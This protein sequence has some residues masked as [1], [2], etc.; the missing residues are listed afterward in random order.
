MYELSISHSHSQT[1]RQHYGMMRRTRILEI[2]EDKYKTKVNVV[3]ITI[4]MISTGLASLNVNRSLGL[5]KL[6]PKFL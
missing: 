4:P 5:E 2:F 1:G 3:D 6:H